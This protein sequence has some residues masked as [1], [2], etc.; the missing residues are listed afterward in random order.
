MRHNTS[1]ANGSGI[2][3]L[4]LL[5]NRCLPP[6]RQAQLGC[7]KHYLTTK[8]ATG[9]SEGAKFD[10]FVINASLLATLPD[11]LNCANQN[12]IQDCAVVGTKCRL[13]N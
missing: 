10:P 4:P 13:Q 1:K 3:E 8:L 11:S 9:N 12:Q 2:Q 5:Q 7:P 6:S